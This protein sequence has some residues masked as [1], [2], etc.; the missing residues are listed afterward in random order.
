LFR[1]EYIETQHTQ[2]LLLKNRFGIFS[3]FGIFLLFR[4]S[5]Y[6]SLFSIVSHFAALAHFTLERKNENLVVVV[7]DHSTN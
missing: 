6:F 3:F 1:K 4:L 2:K 5:F 7:V